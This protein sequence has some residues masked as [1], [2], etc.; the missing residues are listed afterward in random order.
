MN[1]DTSDR[2]TLRSFLDKIEKTYGKAKSTYVIDHGNPTEAILPE[3]PG[4][5]R[6]K[7]RESV[8]VKLF[9]RDSG[10]YVLTKS[11]GRR[12]KATATRRRRL[13]RLLKKLRA[14]RQSLPSLAQ[15]LM[16]LGSAKASRTFQFV[17]AQV[18]GEG[19]ELTRESF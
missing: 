9:E 18:P 3:M 17:H 12:A 4:P 16:R 6:E 14:M 1:G 15:L 8:E 5:A 11:E 2:T 7:V 19:Q 13:A 10:L